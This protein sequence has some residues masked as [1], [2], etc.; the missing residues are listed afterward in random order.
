MWLYIYVRS[1]GYAEDAMSLCADLLM[2]LPR[3]A[4][5]TLQHL[6]TLAP[7]SRLSASPFCYEHVGY[8]DRDGTSEVSAAFSNATQTLLFSEL[9]R[10]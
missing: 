2:P 9:M 8:T 7:N 3:Q 4:V 10:I 6:G 5:E 1:L